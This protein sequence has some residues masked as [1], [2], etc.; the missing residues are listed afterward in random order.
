MVGPNTQWSIASQRWIGACLLAQRFRA[1]ICCPEGS[2]SALPIS[3]HCAGGQAVTVGN[4]C[5]VLSDACFPGGSQ[6]DLMRVFCLPC[7]DLWALHQEHGMFSVMQQ[8]VLN[9]HEYFCYCWL[10][11][12]FSRLFPVRVHINK[13]VH[14]RWGCHGQYS[15]CNIVWLFDLGLWSHIVAVFTVASTSLISEE[16]VNRNEICT[17]KKLFEQK[18]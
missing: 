15:H 18:Y 4:R 12:S 9:N 13:S 5:A 6:Q 7:P 16:I 14:L 10:S 17:K 3:G 2:L 11:R 8:E 1:V